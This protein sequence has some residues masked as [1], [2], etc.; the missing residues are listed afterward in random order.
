M[1]L[2]VSYLACEDKSPL[3]PPPYLLG[4]L[5]SEPFICVAYTHVFLV[6]AK[7]VGV[8]GDTACQGLGRR[9][10]CLA[11]REKMGPSCRLF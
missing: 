3:L 9:W 11:E 8:L 10:P 5:T 7:F 6:W 4:C 1:A 2:I